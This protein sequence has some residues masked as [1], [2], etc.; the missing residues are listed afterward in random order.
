MH[1]LSLE[2]YGDE[3]P[4]WSVTMYFNGI[5]MLNAPLDNRCV[6]PFT[7]YCLLFVVPQRTLK[8]VT[9]LSR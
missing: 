1:F 9:L 4:F 6:H 7:D 5:L 2:V 3:N 8:P